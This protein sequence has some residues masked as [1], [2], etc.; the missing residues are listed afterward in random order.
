MATGFFPA[1]AR[2]GVTLIEAVLYISIALGLIVGG[3][4]FYQQATFSA[5]MNDLTRL[6]T[7]IMAQANLTANTQRLNPGAGGGEVDLSNAFVKM[8]AVPPEYIHTF[9]NGTSVI[10]H[11]WSERPPVDG[12]RIQVRLS[13][14]GANTLPNFQIIFLHVPVEVC[15][16][17]TAFSE[18]GNGLFGGGQTMVSFI[19]PV[20]GQGWQP[21]VGY[22]WMG[23]TSNTGQTIIGITPGEAADFCG[24]ARPPGISLHFQPGRL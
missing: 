18:D 12:H 3:L 11:P 5:R 21:M 10:L 6:M 7:G 2:R 4:V 14:T 24:A 13:S 23:A 16:R 9:D 8:E 20:P 1:M 17:I 19:N 22:Q 15:T